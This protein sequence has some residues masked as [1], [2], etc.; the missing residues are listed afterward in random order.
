MSSVIIAIKFLK[1]FKLQIQLSETIINT[2]VIVI[3]EIFQYEVRK[4]KFDVKKPKKYNQK[5]SDI[6]NELYLIITEYI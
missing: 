5:K 4:V 6:I 3:N 1:N 2:I